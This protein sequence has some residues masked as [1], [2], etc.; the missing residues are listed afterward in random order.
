LKHPPNPS[1][2]CAV[3]DKSTFRFNASHRHPGLASGCDCQGESFV[4][5]THA[6]T[7]LPCAEPARSCALAKNGI[8]N[9]GAT[10][11]TVNAVPAPCK[12]RRR[13]HPCFIMAEQHTA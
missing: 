8:A 2:V 12:N 6:A 4:V 9:P 11:P 1:I 7:S 5:V 3:A 13:V 10:V